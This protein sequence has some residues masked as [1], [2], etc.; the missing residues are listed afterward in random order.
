MNLNK[1]M[2]SILGACIMTF[3]VSA[4]DTIL[5]NKNDMPILPQAGEFAI[6]F[7]AVPILNWVGNT[8]NSNTNN[9]FI[10]Q[11]KPPF[12]PLQTPRTGVGCHKKVGA[13][14]SSREVHRGVAKA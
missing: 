10:G 5:T 13:A 7:N 11:N 8:F 2:L 4:Q 12:Y 9:Q 14:P 1:K 3:S 6:G